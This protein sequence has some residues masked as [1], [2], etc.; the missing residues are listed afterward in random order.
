MRLKSLNFSPVLL[1]L[2]LAARVVIS[3][4]LRDWCTRM[5]LAKCGRI[6]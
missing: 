6:G 3:Y 5:S 1:D 2:N 4:C